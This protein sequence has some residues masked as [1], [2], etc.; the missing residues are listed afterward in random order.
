VHARTFLGLLLTDKEEFDDADDELEEALELNPNFWLTHA[1]LGYLYA[2]QGDEFEDKVFYE[3]ALHRLNEARKLA[4]QEKNSKIALSII[5]VPLGYVKGQ[6]GQFGSARADFLRAK[7]IE[8]KDLKIK[9]NLRRINEA[10]RKR[11]IS[12]VIYGFT[13]LIAAAS[14]LAFLGICWLF[15][16]GRSQEKQFGYMALGFLG[17]SLGAL[18]LPQA[19]KFK[20]G[21][22][23]LELGSIKPLSAH[24]RLEI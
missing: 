15:W 20:A 12:Y 1:G 7:K 9:R 13:G 14:F 4:S 10:M 17:L 6:L 16:A 5:Y 21:P 24:P 8:P 18:Y 22:V 3:D 11:R 2:K 19:T 23:E